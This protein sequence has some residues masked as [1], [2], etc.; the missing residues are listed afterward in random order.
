MVCGDPPFIESSEVLVVMRLYCLYDRVAEEAGNVFEQKNDAL[1]LRMFRRY[2]QEH[3]A[4][5][6]ADYQ[7]M[8]VGTF[9]RE[10]AAIDAAPSPVEVYE[11]ALHL[12]DEESSV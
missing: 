6:P 7:V 5:D 11:G 1:A 12:A 3:P 4:I 9:D 2:L 8:F 10:L